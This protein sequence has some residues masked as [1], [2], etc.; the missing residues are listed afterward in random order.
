MGL[1]PE[2]GRGWDHDVALAGEL[3]FLP[4]SEPERFP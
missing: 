2:A 3:N 1:M 4:E